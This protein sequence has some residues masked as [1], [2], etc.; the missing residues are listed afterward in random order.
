MLESK[1]E[2]KAINA[3]D[4]LINFRRSGYGGLVNIMRQL[5]PFVNAGL[6]ALHIGL[7]TITGKS[8]NPITRKEAWLRMMNTGGQLMVAALIYAALM[9]DEDEYKKLDPSEKDRNIIMPN[10][11]KLPMRNDLFTFFFK[12]V[13]E[14]MYNR[15]IEQSEDGTKMQRALVTAF[16]KA[17]AVPGSLPSAISPMV[18][19]YLNVDMR[20]GR[21][22]VGQGQAGLDP[23]L[24]VSPKRTS[25][26]ARMIGEA[27]DISPLQVDHFLQGY[28]AATAS[29]MTMFTN[30]VIADMRGEV[31]PTKTATEMA[32]EFPF[33]SS[34]V[35][36]ENGARNMMDFYELQ[37]LVNEAYK[38]YTNLKR[39]NYAKSQQYLNIDNNR[40]LVALE[41]HMQNISKSLANLRTYETK[42]LL[43]TTN[44]WSADKKRA[45]LDR[46]EKRRQDMLGFQDEI[47]NRKERHIQKLR[48]QGGL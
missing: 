6:Q 14:H 47:N 13:P 12:I 35:T 9:A 27:G 45:E 5:A 42:L 24:Q 3:A 4:E 43:D 11:F 19:S 22:I 8:I 25:Q 17:M 10:G 48:I 15:Y 23:E 37:E 28:F 2:A 31:L 30:S 20:T 21:P 29:I 18:E 34:F 46:I 39:N 26:L 40:E 1:D 44:R 32:L 41:K 7:A 16:K 38:S 33:V 36:R